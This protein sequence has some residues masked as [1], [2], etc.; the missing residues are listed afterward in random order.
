MYT[1]YER[2]Y[3][4]YLM[5][6]GVKGMRW[7]VKRMLQKMGKRYDS[8]YSH[9]GYDQDKKYGKAMQKS[10]KNDKS[11]IM[12]MN[13]KYEIKARRSFDSH[14]YYNLDYSQDKGQLNAKRALKINNRMSDAFEKNK[15]T[16]TKLAANKSR[17]YSV[18]GKTF[19]AGAGAIAAGMAIAKFG[20]PKN[21]KLMNIGKNLALGGFTAASLSGVGLLGGMHYGEKQF[22]LENDIY[23]RTKRSTRV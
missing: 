9:Y 19:L 20:N 13:N 21:Q 15:G 3:S 7:G 10:I 12:G 14:K 18:G 1:D 22:K 23:S 16:L 8:D 6:H 5:H 17:A 11:K 4:N 2:V